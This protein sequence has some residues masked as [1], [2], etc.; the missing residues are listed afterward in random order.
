MGS[1][2]CSAKHIT[3]FT[4]SH[5]STKDTNVEDDVVEDA[6]LSKETNRALRAAGV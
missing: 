3:T 4:N 6:D 1:L 2:D 5:S